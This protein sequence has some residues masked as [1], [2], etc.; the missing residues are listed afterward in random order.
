MGVARFWLV[1]I[2]SLDLISFAASFPLGIP[3]AQLAE[4]EDV[5][6]AIRGIRPVGAGDHA[7]LGRK[8]VASAF[9]GSNWASVTET[10]L[11]QGYTS[12]V[13]LVTA[14]LLGLTPTSRLVEKG[15]VA[16]RSLASPRS[17]V[18]DLLRCGV[19]FPRTRNLRIVDPLGR[20]IESETR[21]GSRQWSKRRIVLPHPPPFFAWHQVFLENHRAFPVAWLVRHV[22]PVSSQE[23][24]RL[25][26]GIAPGDDFD[27][28]TEALST[29]SI[30]DLDPRSIDGAPEDPQPPVEVLR[31][32]EDEVRLAAA[33]TTHA[34]LVTSELWHPG[35]SATIDA[36]P[37]NVHLVNAGFRAVVVPPGSHEIVFAYRP[38]STRLGL[39]VAALCLVLLMVLM[40][41]ARR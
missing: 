30:G 23:A 41:G 3:R 4:V 34:L 10:P 32:Q 8:L 27:P 12:L 15:A 5:L 26:R 2:L 11:L 33:P 28:T 7:E 1:S 22:R 36:Q 20:A 9:F 16:D 29:T 6:E 40:M 13:P 19:Y 25:V 21:A 38:A 31:Y 14:D 17:H 18:L 37:A 24:L 35:W 39:A